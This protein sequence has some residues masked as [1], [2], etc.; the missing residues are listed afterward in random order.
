MHKKP[1]RDGATAPQRS[2]NNST[3]ATIVPRG[4]LNEQSVVLKSRAAPPAT[5]WWADPA[6]RDRA[7]FRQAVDAR[8][9]I[10]RL[11]C[12]KRTTHA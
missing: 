7:R 12:E 2:W 9:A 5:S 1:R 11:V 8:A 10:L 6:L 3:G 4:I